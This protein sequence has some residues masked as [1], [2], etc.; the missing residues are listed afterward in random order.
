MGPQM[1]TFT[2]PVVLFILVNS[3]AKTVPGRWGLKSIFDPGEGQME[4]GWAVGGAGGVLATF[5][6]SHDM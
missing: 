6:K 4:E 1:L 3:L 2:P 5:K